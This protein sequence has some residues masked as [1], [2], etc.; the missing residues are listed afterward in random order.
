MVFDGDCNFCTLWIHRWHQS[1][2]ERV[3]Y[4]AFQDPHVA[5]RFPELSREKFEA[6]VHFIEP[7]GAV[8][9]GAEAVFRSLAAN[10]ARAWL[11]RCYETIPVFSSAT[12]W[13]YRFVAEHRTLFSA[14]TR[15]SWG[16]HVDRPTHSLTRWTFLRALGAIY[17]VAFLSLW[18]QIGGLVGHNGILPVRQTMSSAAQQLNAQGIGLG[19][20]RLVPTLCWFS[21]S[22]GFLQ[23]QCAAGASLAVLLLIGV[24]PAPCLALRG[25]LALLRDSARPLRPERRHR[26]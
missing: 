16:R 10:P 3:E 25:I 26:P 19:R 4:I 5:S 14:L 8:Y 22:D 17:L 9:S 23:F 7:D 12:E 13:A 20:F 6:A 2:V 24:A 1:T 11:R 18:M 21:T 15:F